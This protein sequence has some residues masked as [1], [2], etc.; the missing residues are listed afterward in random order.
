[1]DLTTLLY[2]TGAS[3]FFTS[4]AFIPAFFTAVFIRYGHLFPFLGDQEFLQITGSEPTWFTNNWTILALGVLS[5]IEIGATKIP[6]AQEVMESIH[7]Y[8]KTGAAAMAAMGVL[9]A[10]DV[11]FIEQT[12]SHLRQDSFGILCVA[13]KHLDG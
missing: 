12:I 11:G 3:G 4:R 9:G 1:M 7:K 8:T 6:E 13:F 2:L 5:I 10:R